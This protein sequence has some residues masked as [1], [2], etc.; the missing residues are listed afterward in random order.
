MVFF[1]SD[2][3][4]TLMIHSYHSSLAT[5]NTG[6]SFSRS[7][8]F[9]LCSV[10]RTKS[11]IQY[12][13]SFFFFSFSF[14]FFGGGW[15]SSGLVSWPGWGDPFVSQNHRKFKASHWLGRILVCAYTIS[16]NGQISISCSI[17]SR[18]PFPPSHV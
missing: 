6:P 4:V 10:R 9:S 15:I 14:L 1:F 7:F 5:S 18:S 12:V 13:P 16:L 8:V 2:I 11:T 3:T 17:L